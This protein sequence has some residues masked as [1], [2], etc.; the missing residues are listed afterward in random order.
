M[1][2]TKKWFKIQQVS[3]DYHNP[4][5]EGLSSSFLGEYGWKA[6]E[7][8]WTWRIREERQDRG[9]EG[10]A[11]KWKDQVMQ[12]QQDENEQ[13]EHQAGLKWLHIM[14]LG[15][16]LSNHSAESILCLIIQKSYI[17]KESAGHLDYSINTEVFLKGHF[18]KKLNVDPS[19]YWGEPGRN[20]SNRQI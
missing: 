8:E 5:L 3:T 12:E 7:M 2:N 4:T 10:A 15:N 18:E 1:P 13:A 14:Q 6:Q 16:W 20:I 17:Q 19:S 11:R 9:D